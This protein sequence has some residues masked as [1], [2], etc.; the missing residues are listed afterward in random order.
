MNVT[1]YNGIFIQRGKLFKSAQICDRP[2]KTT[3]EHVHPYGTTKYPFPNGKQLLVA[4]G[5]RGR[6]NR[7]QMH[8]L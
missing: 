6:K 1:I 7:Y 8:H 5:Y 3:K 2:F 4:V